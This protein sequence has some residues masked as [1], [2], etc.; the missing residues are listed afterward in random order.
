MKPDDKIEETAENP[1]NMWNDP[2]EA[3]VQSE[4]HLI[5]GETQ[6]KDPKADPKIIESFD[7][8]SNEVHFETIENAYG[9]IPTKPLG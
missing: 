4:Q 8:Q 1:V 7:G 5:T 6:L 2:V 9:S 3:P